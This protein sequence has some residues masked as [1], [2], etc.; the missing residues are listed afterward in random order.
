[1]NTRQTIVIIVGVFLELVIG[2]FPPYYFNGGLIGGTGYV[3]LWNIPKAP[4]AGEGINIQLWIQEGISIIPSCILLR[5]NASRKETTA[6]SVVW[7]IMSCLIVTAFLQRNIIFAPELIN[8]SISLFS[9]I[10][11]GMS[12]FLWTSSKVEG[13][14]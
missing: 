1:M 7:I 14:P 9:L 13:T 3:P 8:D 10:V 12:L 4:G 2:L 5:N 11:L 6:A